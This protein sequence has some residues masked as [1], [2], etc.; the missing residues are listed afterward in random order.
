MA[1]WPGD[2]TFTTTPASRMTR[3][4]SCNVTE[5]AMTTHCGTHFDAPWHFVAEG[6]RIDEVDPA[7]FFGDALLIELP[8]IDLI[9]AENLGQAPLPRRVLFKTRNTHIPDDSPFREDFVGL[10]PDAAQRIV[11]DGCRLVGVD[12]L[13]V[14][15]FNQSGDETHHLLLANNVLVIEGLRF[16]GLSSGTYQFVALPLPLSGLDGSPCR[17]FI[18]QESKNAR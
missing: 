14:A 10:A 18:G 4:D 5:F 13:S 12:Y 7:L 11:D 6:I 3:G 9:R 16:N 17:A 15:P 2:Q 8:G 1:T